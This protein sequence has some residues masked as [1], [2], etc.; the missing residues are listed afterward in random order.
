LCTSF[1]FLG[2]SAI[3]AF[4][5]TSFLRTNKREQCTCFGVVKWC[6]FRTRKREINSWKIRSLLLLTSTKNAMEPSQYVVDV[7]VLAMYVDTCQKDEREAPQSS[8]PQ[9]PSPL[10]LQPPMRLFSPTTRM[11]ERIY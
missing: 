3:D 7:P 11:T 10:S 5:D 6:R 1:F 8:V 4:L 2:F 9:Q